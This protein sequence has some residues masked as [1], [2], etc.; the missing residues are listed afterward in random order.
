MI[1]TR[2]DITIQAG[3]TFVQD[4]Q[5]MNADGTTPI[6]ITGWTVTCQIRE[7]PGGLLIVAPTVTLTPLEGK[8]R[9][10]LTSVQTAALTSASIRRGQY[11]VR[12]VLPDSSIKRFVEGIAVITPQ[13]TT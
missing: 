9:L 8:I 1:G 4:F 5:Y 10:S 2:H 7:R 3:A 12:A 13:V 11:D 6:D